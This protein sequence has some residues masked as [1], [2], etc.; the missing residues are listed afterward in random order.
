MNGSRAWLLAALLLAPPALAS[1]ASPQESFAA[2]V[3]AHERGA[4]DEAID[5]L[6]LLADRGL[7]HPDAS[8]NRAAAYIA[9]ARSPGAR[10][11]DLGRAAAALAETLELRPGDEQAEHAL[12]AVQSEIA[13]RRARDGSEPVAARP[14][15]ARAV[16]GLLPESVWAAAAAVGSL[17][18]TI[19]LALRFSRRRR[20]RLGGAIAAGIGAVLLALAASLTLAARSY[21]LGSEPAVVVA[22]DARMLDDKGAPMPARARGEPTSIPEGAMVHLL[23][24]RGTLARIEWGTTTAWVDVGQIRVLARR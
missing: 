7:S 23:E 2:A 9:R 10:P 12:E 24:R 20:P 19:G 13:R 3:T 22:T 18:L 8:F 14:S 21:R 4:W 6:E 16:V 15:L 17:A 1:E 5:Q 11:G